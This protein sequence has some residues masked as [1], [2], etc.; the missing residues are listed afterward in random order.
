M[1]L[2]ISLIFNPFNYVY[3]LIKSHRFLYFFLILYCLEHILLAFV[4]SSVAL[5]IFAAPLKLSVLG[6]FNVY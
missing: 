4:F 3:F 5:E 2:L 1:F 6:I